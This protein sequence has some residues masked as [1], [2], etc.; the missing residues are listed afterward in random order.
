MTGHTD[1]VTGCADMLLVKNGEIKV[2]ATTHSTRINLEWRGLEYDIAE[3]ILDSGSHR[4]ELMNL[5]F[6]GPTLY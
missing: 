6:M 3:R 4:L 2:K 1:G 5:F